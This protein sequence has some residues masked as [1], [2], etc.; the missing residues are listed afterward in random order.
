MTK[1]LFGFSALYQ[2]WRIC[3]GRVAVGNYIRLRRKWEGKCGALNAGTRAGE[4][5]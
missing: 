3:S 1:C 4:Y 2:F 5:V